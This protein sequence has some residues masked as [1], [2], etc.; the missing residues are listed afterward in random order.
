M[1]CGWVLIFETRCMLP[2][3]PEPC[4]RFPVACTVPTLCSNH[5]AGKWAEVMGRTLQANPDCKV[6]HVCTWHH[7]SAGVVISSVLDTKVG[8]SA[9]T[10]SCASAKWSDRSNAWSTVTQLASSPALAFS[11]SH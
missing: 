3:L 11:R 2:F 5:A 7:T 4:R 1:E 9:L 6:N 8:N 10:W